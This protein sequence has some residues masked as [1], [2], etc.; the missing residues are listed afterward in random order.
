MGWRSRVVQLQGNTEQERKR[1]EITTRYEWLFHVRAFLSSINYKNSKKKLFVFEIN[2]MFKREHKVSQ[3]YHSGSLKKAWNG[4]SYFTLPTAWE[5]SNQP[6]HTV[7][8][9]YAP[10]MVLAGF[11]ARCPR[12]D[13][14]RICSG[15]E[16][17]GND[18]PRLLSAQTPRICFCEY[19]KLSYKNR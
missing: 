16:E 4:V 13:F 3:W 14:M 9:A 17:L 7:S 8:L 10:V 11:L 18:H 2:W 1:K 5:N 19:Q 15:I 6:P 12:L